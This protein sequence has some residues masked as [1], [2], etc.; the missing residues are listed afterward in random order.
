MTKPLFKISLP[1][2]DVRTASP[3]QCVVHSD[4]ASPKINKRA[5]PPHRGL[6]AISINNTTFAAGDTVIY[7]FAH[8]YT[9]TP[10][11]WAVF[12]DTNRPGIFGFS[13]FVSGIVSVETRT[14]D[15]FFSLV[16]SDPFGFAL[17]FDLL[18]SYAIFAENGK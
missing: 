15:T 16:V 8:G 10:Q 18:C 17:T 3:E 14:D 6:L 2:V 5:N 11:V 13:P 12:V 9:Y 1:G 4:Y 7:R